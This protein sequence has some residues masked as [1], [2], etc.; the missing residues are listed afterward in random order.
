MFYRILQIKD[1]SKLEEKKHGLSKL[2]AFLEM[3]T[4]LV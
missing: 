2:E 3:E 4:F 1:G